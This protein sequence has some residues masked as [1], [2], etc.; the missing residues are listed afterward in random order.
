[1]LSGFC[2]PMEIRSQRSGQVHLRQ[3]PDGAYEAKTTW[4][5]P[6]DFPVLSNPHPLGKECSYARGSGSRWPLGVGLKGLAYPHPH[7]QRVVYA[8]FDGRDVRRCC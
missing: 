8:Y 6:F 1:M 3:R 4:N 7:R 5:A 2:L